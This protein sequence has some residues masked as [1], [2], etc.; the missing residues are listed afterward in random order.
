MNLYTSKLSD[1]L[2]KI[3]IRDKINKEMRRNIAPKH[4]A[5]LLFDLFYQKNDRN[6]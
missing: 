1:Y 5:L 4:S 3:Y 2:Q 6:E